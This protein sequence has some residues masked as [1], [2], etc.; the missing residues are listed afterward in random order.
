MKKIIL[1]S[2]IL[3]LV[4][5]SSSAKELT[6]KEKAIDYKIK[7][8]KEFLNVADFFSGD[9]ESYWALTQAN[10]ILDSITDFSKHEESY[11]RIYAAT[12]YISYGMSYIQTFANA[13]SENADSFPKIG[14]QECSNI[15]IKDYHKIKVDTSYSLKTLVTNHLEL[16]SKALFSI[17]YFYRNTL[18]YPDFKDFILNNNYDK[19]S[20][21]LTLV[22]T[23]SPI[24]AYRICSVLNMQVWYNYIVFLTQIAYGIN[25]SVDPNP[26]EQPW[27]EFIELA[28]WHDSLTEN[29]EAYETMSDEDF[30]QIE[31][32]AAYT[33]YIMLSNMAKN[34]AEFKE[35]ETIISHE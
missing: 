33:Q 8:L 5:I 10:S 25:N 26:N 1:F 2:L 12:S 15:I 3:S 18:H 6:A 9:D 31:Q 11:A 27:K 22:S 21:Y 4:C 34:I 32:K 14:L 17:M 20:S 30:E 19:F 16:E 13:K 23:H 29:L 35:K 28:Y 24:T 7:G